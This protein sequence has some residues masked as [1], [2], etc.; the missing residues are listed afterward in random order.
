MVHFKNKKSSPLIKKL[1]VSQ[2]ARSLYLLSMTGLLLAPH[3]PHAPRIGHGKT[4]SSFQMLSAFSSWGLMW[5]ITSPKS[6]LSSC[7]ERIALAN[8]CCSGESDSM[9]SRNSSEGMISFEAPGQ[10][11][12][13]A[14]T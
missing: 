11:C 14:T 1:T 9:A 10:G 7:M 8:L 5:T 3:A 13:L 2:S 6:V 4:D 12:Q